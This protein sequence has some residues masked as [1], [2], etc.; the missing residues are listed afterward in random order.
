[1][2]GG[3]AWLLMGGAIGAGIAALVLSEREPAYATGY[4]GVEDVARKTF[5]WGAKQR[6]K[7]KAGSV[8]GR[9]KAGVGRFTGDSD[10]EAEGTI[11]KVAGK[12]RDIAGEAGQAAAQ[13][14][15][16]LNKS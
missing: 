14:I 12:V 10:L 5:G 2:R 11:E 16:D 9:M 8:V 13:T 6:V 7:G 4:D 1:M 15:H 3:L